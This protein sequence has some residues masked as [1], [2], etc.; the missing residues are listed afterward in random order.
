MAWSNLVDLAQ[1]PD[2]QEDAYPGIPSSS[3]SIYPYGLR[4]ALCDEEM[5]K[6]KLD[7]EDCKIGDLVDFRAFGV[8]TSISQNDGPSGP[9]ARVEIQIQKMA[10]EEEMTGDDAVSQSP[11]KSR[12]SALYRG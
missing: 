3:G 12:R 11:A 5:A 9:C 10:L 1:T 2:E 7:P 8:I 4:I 6:L